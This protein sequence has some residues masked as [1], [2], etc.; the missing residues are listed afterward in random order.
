MAQIPSF[1]KIRPIKPVNTPNQLGVSPSLATKNSL[2]F[3]MQNQTQTQWCW[4]AVSTSISL[5]YQSGS[6]WRQCKVANKAWSRTDCCGAGASGLCNN[7]WYLDRALKLVEVFD[8]MTGASESFVASKSE[9]DSGNPLCLRVGWSNGGGH[10]LAIV[11]WRKTSNGNEYYDVDDPIYGRQTILKFQL[12]SS[13]QGRGKWTHSYFVAQNPSGGGTILIEID[14]P[15]M[16][17]A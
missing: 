11:G 17:G 13:Y 14:D 7:P 3:I 15:E 4:A 9:I 8:R 16:L 12:E 5:F 2:N 10:F 6:T 1:L